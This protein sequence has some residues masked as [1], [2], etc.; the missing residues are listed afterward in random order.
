[1]RPSPPLRLRCLVCEKAPPGAAALDCYESPRL[2]CLG[3]RAAEEE[4][5]PL[6]F[7]KCLCSRERTGF[8]CQAPLALAARAARDGRPLF[9]NRDA[10]ESPRRV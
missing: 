10:V 7:W 9:G 8:F 4:R 2:V 5:Q 1:M 6:H 3:G